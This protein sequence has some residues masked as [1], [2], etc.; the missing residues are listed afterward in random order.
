VSLGDRLAV[1]LRD[2][3]GIAFCDGCVALRLEATLMEAREA[4]NALDG[5][6]GYMT[7]TAGCSEC[8]RTKTVIVGGLRT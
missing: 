5:K 2:N 1:L 7:G 4:M 3:P 8:L 6:P